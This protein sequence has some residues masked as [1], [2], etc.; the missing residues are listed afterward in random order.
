MASNFF[1]NNLAGNPNFP[2]NYLDP[3]E[4]IM[5]IVVLEIPSVAAQVIGKGCANINRLATHYGTSITKSDFNSATVLK[6]QGK[7]ADV[8]AVKQEILKD[9]AGFAALQSAEREALKAMVN[10]NGHIPMTTVKLFVPICY[11]GI[12]IGHKGRTI[13]QL[14][15]YH[16]VI[17]YKKKFNDNFMYFSIY[18]T[19]LGVHNAIGAVYKLLQEQCGIRFTA[20]QNLTGDEV[21]FEE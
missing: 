21:Y 19:E 8:C 11:A 1:S 16:M 2:F 10:F 4:L 20:T 17:M 3:N 6:I 18:G 14:K 12:V 13:A 15:A 9:S 5:D 7:R